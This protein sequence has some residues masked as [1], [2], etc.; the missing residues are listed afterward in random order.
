MTRTHR[1][2]ASDSLL[3]ALKNTPM[4]EEAEELRLARA[5]Q[6]GSEPAFTALVNAHLR[7]VAKIAHESTR[8][9]L[10]LED[11]V[12]EGMLGLVEATRRFDPE[13][14]VRLAGYAAWWI[15]AYVRRYTIQNRRIVRPPSTRRGRRVLSNLRKVQHALSGT[16]GESA[17]VE[18]VAEALQVSVADVHEVDGA[19]SGRD[20]AL[21]SE[22]NGRTFEVADASPSPEDLVAEAEHRM[23]EREAVARALRAL[24]PREKKILEH[25]YLGDATVSLSR[26]GDKLGLSRERIRQL[27]HQAQIKVRETVLPS[28]A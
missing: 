27:E 25:R 9:G 15:R 19:L 26:I 3:K 16:G 11:L 12:S 13:R 6:A 28:V 2:A 4:L 17:T 20:V 22:V 5:A 21:L 1:T 24:D 8:Y 7:L 10:P 18:Q 14:G 23:R